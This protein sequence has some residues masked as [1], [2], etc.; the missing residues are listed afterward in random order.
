MRGQ[1][2]AQTPVLSAARHQAR[3]SIQTQLATNDLRA[4]SDRA[5][6]NA[7]R[8][9]SSKPLM[10]K[11][12]ET[13]LAKDEGEKSSNGGVLEAATPSNSTAE[14]DAQTEEMS[15]KNNQSPPKAADGTPANSSPKKRR[16]LVSI[17]DDR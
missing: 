13:Q 14:R 6:A 1:N 16:K 12:G 10:T 4:E 2:R 15:T 7:H 8:T 3:R 17:A 11:D 5:S 9:A